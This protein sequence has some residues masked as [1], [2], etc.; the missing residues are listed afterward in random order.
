[1]RILLITFLATLFLF[2][3]DVVLETNKGDIILEIYED[4]TP[5]TAENFLTHV[6]NGY[7]DGIIFHRVIKDFMI[8]TGDPTG[9]GRGGESIY[10]LPFKDE[11]IKGLAFDEAGVLAMANKG[12]GTNGSQFFITTANAYW[13][14][15]KHTIFGK[16]KDGYDVVKTI[17]SAKTD[18]R[19]KPIE[20]IK[21]ERAYILK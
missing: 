17:E 7:Y 3:K 12:P 6:K 15:G 20:E 11:I 8:Q 4:K 18:S 13:L 10:G 21:I 19:D 9:T 5:I 1:M 2:A 14:N 16:V